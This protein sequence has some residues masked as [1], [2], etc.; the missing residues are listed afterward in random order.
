MKHTIL[1]TCLCAAT[2]FALSSAAL[3]QAPV[4]NPVT[5]AITEAWNGAKRNVH[6]SATLMPEDGYAFKPVATVRT[7][8]AM[9]AHVAGAN[10]VFCSP[11][12]GEKSPYAE[13]HFEKTATTKAQ[14]VAALDQSLAYCDKAFAAATDARLAEM[15]AQPFGE[16]K[17]PRAAA[18]IGN[19]GH[20]NDHYGNLVTYFRIKGMVPPSSMPRQ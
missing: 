14:I 13:D 8:G 10:Y 2:T 1:T 6:E 3:A 5:S 19:T 16:G 12:L 7:F 9:L 15:V 20:L 11:A 18:L 4:T 17:A